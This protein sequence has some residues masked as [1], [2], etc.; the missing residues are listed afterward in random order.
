M[1][2]VQRVMDNITNQSNLNILEETFEI[3]NVFH[4]GYLLISLLVFIIGFLV[5]FSDV[6]TCASMM[7]TKRV[8]YATRFLTSLTL[9]CDATYVLVFLVAYVSAMIVNKQNEV[10][11]SLLSEIARICMS[12]SYVC[13]SL[14]SVERV[15]CL[16]FGS[17]YSK[18]FN[19][20]KAYTYLSIVVSSFLL[21]KLSIRYIIIP[22]LTD[23][24]FDLVKNSGD[25]KIT[26][27]VLGISLGVSITCYADI[28]VIIRRHTRHMN[29]HHVRGIVSNRQIISRSYYSTRAVSVIFI[30]FIVLHL[31]LL[32]ALFV[33]H[34]RS[35]NVSARYLV[36]VSGIITS[37]VNPILYAWR[38]K[39]CRFIIKASIHKQCGIFTNSVNAMRIDIYNIVINEGPSNNNRSSGDALSIIAERFAVTSTKHIL[40][41][42]ESEH[43]PVEV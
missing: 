29:T 2:K 38:F 37:G 9:M 12:T 28:Y 40:T 16:N 34:S 15:L 32:V 10:A 33:H 14:M 30:V 26:L 4:G 17:Y 35:D 42:S 24:N 25:L 41:R 36:L 39:E 5:F 11:V 21:T 23:G 43:V 6:I 27:L 19:N 7:C 22:L 3:K 18:H 31:P 8:P 13:I 20:N 1:S